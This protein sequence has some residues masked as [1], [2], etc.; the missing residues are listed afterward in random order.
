MRNA[1]LEETQ[2]AGMDWDWPI[3]RKLLSSMEEQLYQ[4]PKPVKAPR[5]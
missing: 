2:K 5:L 1:G 3:V 4:S